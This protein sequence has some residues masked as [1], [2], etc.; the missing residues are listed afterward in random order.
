MAKFKAE[1]Y[2][3]DP[4]GEQYYACPSCGRAFKGSK[5]VETGTAQCPT[6]GVE[7]A[8]LDHLLPQKEQ[9]QPPEPGPKLQRIGI[10]FKAGGRKDIICEEYNPK[11]D[12]LV[13][14]LLRLAIKGAVPPC[15]IYVDAN[16]IDAIVIMPLEET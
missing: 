8:G 9:E 2:H 16:N 6:C 5:A 14:G 12:I 7:L 10:Y 11:E 1:L 15:P 3:T 4:A 13:G